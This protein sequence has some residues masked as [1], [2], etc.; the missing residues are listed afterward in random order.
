M[1]GFILTAFGLIKNIIPFTLGIK[2]LK[3]WIDNNFRDK[4]IPVKGSVLYCDLYVLAEHSGIYIGNRQISNICVDGLAEA[5]VESSDPDDFTAKSTMH[6]RIY[7][8]SNNHGAVGDDSVGYGAESHIGERN[9]YGLVFN[10]CHDFSKK[11]LDYS[12]QT[13]TEDSFLSGIMDESWESTIRQLKKTARRKIGATKWLLWDWEND[14]SGGNN[15]DKSEM[16]NQDG[17]KDFYDNLKLDANSIGQLKNQLSETEDYLQEIADE[18]IPA[19]AI[20]QLQDFKTELKSIV[21]KYNE[22]KE[23]IEATGCGYSFKELNSYSDSY[24][25]LV[26]EMKN[27]KKIQ[28]ITEKLGRNHIS[29]LKKTKT[30]ICKRSKNELFGIHKSNDLIRLLPSELSNFE[31]EELEYLFYSKYL[32]D[33]LLTYELIGKT[34]KEI[35]N[36]K[37]GP[38]IA[39]LDTSGSMMGKPI[40][41]AKALLFAIAGIL[42]KENRSLYVLMFGSADQISE[43]VIEKK[44]ET[45]KL[46]CFLKNGFNG[47]TDFE[48][49]LKRGIEIIKENAGYKKADILMITDGLCGIS[50]SFKR[51]LANDKLKLDFSIYTVI[52]DGNSTGKDFSDE[53][54]TI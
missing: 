33:S 8:S 23:F 43:L 6:K 12:D 44:S 45:G 22:A 40:L 54:V 3:Y 41:K 15:G 24:L 39:C 14:N 32:E 4:V 30:I 34:K 18:N 17:K 21:K 16:P 2:A 7:V 35:I 5:E 46:L 1:F 49:P 50:E 31:D 51:K 10:N 48:T 11:C 28:E 19:E 42:E 36:K 29:E 52:C 37:K 26:N 53:V 38:V 20:K 27:N 13:P 47:G 25:S 9:F